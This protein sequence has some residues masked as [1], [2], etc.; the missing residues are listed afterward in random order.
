[1]CC[2]RLN[3]VEVLP[4]HFACAG[5][6]RTTPSTSVPSHRAASVS[7]SQARHV[8]GEGGQGSISADFVGPEAV[9]GVYPQSFTK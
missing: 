6:A 5:R 9:S 2:K 7:G 1:M 8:Y 4:L 3:F